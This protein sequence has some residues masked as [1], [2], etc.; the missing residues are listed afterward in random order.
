MCLDCVSVWDS[1]RLRGSLFLFQTMCVLQMVTM[2]EWGCVCV[3]FMQNFKVNFLNLLKT[4]LMSGCSHHP[5]QCESLPSGLKPN[6]I[7]K[8]APITLKSCLF[9]AISLLIC[10]LCKCYFLI[11]LYAEAFSSLSCFCP[12]WFI[13]YPLLISFSLLNWIYGHNYWVGLLCFLLKISLNKY[14]FT[15]H[16]NI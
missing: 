1:R 3:L 2:T 10:Y 16:R 12:K 11:F 7:I 9:K 6:C 5:L 13:Y 8:G 15:H 14:Y 4:M